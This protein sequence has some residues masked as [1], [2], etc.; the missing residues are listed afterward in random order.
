MSFIYTKSWKYSILKNTLR[1][2]EEKNVD[3]QNPREQKNGFLTYPKPRGSKTGGELETLSKMIWIFLIFFS[4]KNL[5]AHF[6]LSTFFDNINFQITL[7][8]KMMPNV[9]PFRSFFQKGQIKDEYM[10]GYL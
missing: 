7:F 4:L 2:P 1:N 3:P 9:W 5:G 10:I 8:A 6:L